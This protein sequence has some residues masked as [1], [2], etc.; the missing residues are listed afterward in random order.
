MEGAV[1]VVETKP[2]CDAG[3]EETCAVAELPL[4][5]GSR[6]GRALLDEILQHS[7]ANASAALREEGRSDPVSLWQM[8]PA[9]ALCLLQCLTLSH[10]RSI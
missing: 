9:T 4:Q 1:E 8:F 10:F 2:H 6:H 3:K 7:L 5:L